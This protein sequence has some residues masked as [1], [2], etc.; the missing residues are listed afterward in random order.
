MYK[1]INLKFE[2][3]HLKILILNYTSQISTFKFKFKIEVNDKK[4]DIS[5]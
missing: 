4:C 3:T 5:Y 2:N 1:K